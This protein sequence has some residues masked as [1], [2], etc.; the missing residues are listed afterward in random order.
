MILLILL[1]IDVILMLPLK[2]RDAFLCWLSLH[3]RYHCDL[4]LVR[5]HALPFLRQGRALLAWPPLQFTPKSTLLIFLWCIRRI[6]L[7]VLILAVDLPSA[8]SMHSVKY[9]QL[10]VQVV[11]LVEMGRIMMQSVQAV[12]PL[13]DLWQTV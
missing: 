12:L 1:N 2:G 5:L 8:R 13:L 10:L 3:F 4:D 6:H 7:D 9:P 11:D